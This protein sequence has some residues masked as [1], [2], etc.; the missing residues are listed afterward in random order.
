MK[1]LRFLLSVHWIVAALQTVAVAED[2]N[3]ETQIKPL[4]SAK[5]FD[6][7]GPDVQ[8]SH[9]RLDRKSSMLRGGDSGEPAIIVGDSEGSHLIK[10]VSEKEAGK[11]MPPEG[12]DR[13]SKEEIDVLREW[14]DQG[15]VWPGPDGAADDEPGK[16]DHWSF[17]P[18]RDLQ[19]PL[20]N[21]T[22]I[23]KPP[24]DRAPRR[25]SVPSHR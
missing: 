6:C 22:W 10:L 18:V 5:C 12:A 19:P 8:E 14:I 13:L 23:A 24:D 1:T 17:Q 21:N 15:A 16:T 25:A 4:L 9:L 7:H 3:F 20:M 2:V 11:V